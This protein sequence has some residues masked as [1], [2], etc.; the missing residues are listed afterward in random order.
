MIRT[1]VY[2]PETV[3]QAVKLVASQKN[4]TLAD[5]IRLYIVSGLKKERSRKQSQGLESI[6]NLGIAGGP[7]DLSENLDKYLYQ[8]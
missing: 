7:K 8:E 4:K 2:I 6:I 3:H 5:I 1:Q